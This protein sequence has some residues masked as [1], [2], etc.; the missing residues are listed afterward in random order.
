MFDIFSNHLSSYLPTIL[1]TYLPCT[2]DNSNSVNPCSDVSS[3]GPHSCVYGV[4]VHV[5]TA[6]SL[7]SQVVLLYVID[8]S[9]VFV[10][11]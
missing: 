3:R 2:A 9:G 4:L 11:Q 8:F 1:C 6:P 5:L 10:L 7:G